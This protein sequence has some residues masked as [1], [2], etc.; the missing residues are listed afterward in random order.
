MIPQNDVNKVI[1]L[2]DK[3]YTI[4]Q[5]AD[6]LNYTSDYILSIV[7]THNIQVSSGIE[8]TWDWRGGWDKDEKIKEYYKRKYNI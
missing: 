3:G 5:I 4:S 6:E 7:Q 2:A 1:K 8:T